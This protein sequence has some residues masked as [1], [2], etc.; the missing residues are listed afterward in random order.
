MLPFE[1]RSSPFT[2][3]IMLELIETPYFMLFFATVQKF[4]A[5]HKLKTWLIVLPVISQIFVIQ[6]LNL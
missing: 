3:N 6:K 2:L 1:L 4:I 5:Q